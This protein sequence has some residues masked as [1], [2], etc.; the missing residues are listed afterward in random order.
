M[1]HKLTRTTALIL[2]LA[3]PL[4]AF[5]LGMISADD[6]IAGVGIP[7]TVSDLAPNSAVDV[8]IK[9]PDGMSATVHAKTD[10]QGTAVTTVPGSLTEHAGQYS[11]R[12]MQN[13]TDVSSGVQVTVAP[14]SM[15]PWTSTLQVW[16][17]R[18]SADGHDEAE[19]EVRLMDKYG[20]VLAD[21]PVTLISS[22][23]DDHITALTPQTD[24]EGIQHFALSTEEPGVI[25]LRA[26]DLLSGN[27]IVASAQ[28]KAGG[29]MGGHL[30]GDVT[31]GNEDTNG[32]LDR[33]MFY[34]QTVSFDI[35]D[36]FEVTAPQSVQRGVEAQ[37]ITIRAVDRS[38]NT[39]EDYVGTVRF[40][41]TDPEAT[42]PNF[43][44]YT[45][46]ERDLGEKIFPLVLKFRTGGM[47]IFRVEDAND[48]RISGEAE[49]SVDGGGSTGP[50][51][52]IT[53]TS[54]HNEDYVSSLLVTIEGTG[55]RFANLIVMGGISDAVGTTDDNGAFSI[56]ITLSPGQR[57]FTIRVRDD[58]GRNDSGPL[59]LILDQDLPVIKT[60]TFAPEMPEAGANVLVAVESEPG[61]ES[62]SLNM[63][64][65]AMQA[66]HTPLAENPSLPGSYQ[67][68]FTAPAAGS[69][70]PVLTATDKAGNRSEIRTMFS[71][72]MESLP[73][74]QNVRV[75]PRVNSVELEWDAIAG[76]VNGYRI[77][78]GE[79]P[80]DFQNTLDTG[81][82]T[83]KATVAGLTPGKT[84][85]FAVTALKD[86][87][88]SANRS[89]PVS[90]A[91]LGLTLEIKQSE[92]GL[93]VEWPSLSTDLP[94]SSFLLEYTTDAIAA[95]NKTFNEHRMINGQL[96]FYAIRDLL[97]S[98]TYYIRLTPITVTGQKLEDL[99]ATGQ[100]TTPAAGFK[101]S[102]RDDIP[103]DDVQH[104]GATQN[105]AT[106]T[107][108]SGIPALA[109]MTALASGVAGVLWQ[110]HR[111]KRKT[112]AFLHA[113]QS[114]YDR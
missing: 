104:P 42:L 73:V 94:L 51:G 88:E 58:A 77:Y 67:A 97:P 55:P 109:W 59:H 96:S 49:I 46:K 25:Q 103:F 24:D 5:A 112:E 41:S 11:L 110:L 70:Q 71:V 6:S 29:A 93:T 61:L 14:G 63:S 75:E 101:P 3:F 86:N 98:I 19:I 91:V 81:R 69:Y 39:V 105:P 79:S 64:T 18:I 50:A 43:G 68:F 107:P 23:P 65:D 38:G 45:F 20:N 89:D 74:V 37:T 113:I 32:A 26:V 21:R 72:G 85:Y 57:D 60:I 17:P 22:R 90:A 54:H 40:S 27:T 92:G 114:Q 80:V 10:A 34:A 1:S 108:A 13:R 82:V 76:E 36:H 83:T 28:I 47:Q 15:D 102:A 52:G 56:P 12:A 84:Y 66:S 106:S 4:Q 48:A 9:D 53:V 62:V 30:A 100:G 44:T 99:S 33:R 8:V 2:S 95:Q 111:R 16:T 35:I 78:I 7:L 31:Y 87:A